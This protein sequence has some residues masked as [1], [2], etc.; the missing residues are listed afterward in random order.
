[1]DGS[2]VHGPRFICCRPRVTLACGDINILFCSLCN[3]RTK[4]SLAHPE[5][6]GVLDLR[7]RLA[8]GEVAPL[9]PGLEKGRSQPFWLT[10]RAESNT[11]VETQCSTGW[12]SFAGAV[13]VRNTR[14]GVASRGRPA[15]APQPSN[16]PAAAAIITWWRRTTSP[17]RR[18]SLPRRRRPRSPRGRWAPGRGSRSSSTS[19]R[20]SRTRTETR[21]RRRWGQATPAHSPSAPRVAMARAHPNPLSVT[22]GCTPTAPTPLF[23]STPPS[24]T[25]TPITATT[26]HPLTLTIRACLRTPTTPRP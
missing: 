6:L 17:R 5:T 24:S 14:T 12:N 15:P 18:R 3:A 21:P 16:R 13:E 1:M 19:C 25:P 20:T 9:C 10:G 8:G 2:F 11:A 26:L 7:V 22:S 4:G 23:T